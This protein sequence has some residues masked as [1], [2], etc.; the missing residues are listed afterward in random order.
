MILESITMNDVGTDR[1][2]SNILNTAAI[3]LLG[4]MAITGQRAQMDIAQFKTQ[5]SNAEPM[6]VRDEVFKV[7]DIVERM[8]KNVTWTTDR[9]EWQKWREGV[10][11]RLDKIDGS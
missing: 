2:L 10:D 4:W 3:G 5:W 6:R 1:R 9:S 8:S 7:S 11:K